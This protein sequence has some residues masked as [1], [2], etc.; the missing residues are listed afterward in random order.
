MVLVQ[1]EIAG[2]DLGPEGR[3]RLQAR[4]P[5]LA[6]DRGGDVGGAELVDQQAVERRHRHTAGRRGDRHD[7]ELSG[8]RR[9]RLAQLVAA[10]RPLAVEGLVVEV[11]HDVGLADGTLLAEVPPA[12]RGGADGRRREQGR[13]GGERK[14]G[15]QEW[16]PEG[17]RT[18]AIGLREGP[19]EGARPH[20][21]PT[22]EAHERRRQRQAG[23]HHRDEGEGEGARRRAATRAV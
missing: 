2:D 15:E 8:Q 4:A 6:L 9:E 14:Q 20:P 16:N 21:G 19:L 7:A 11:V 10:Q 5:R 17:H 1:A 13:R 3:R 18:V 23:S 12:R 22:I